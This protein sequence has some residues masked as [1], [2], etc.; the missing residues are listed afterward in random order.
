[1]RSTE[2]V[3]ARLGR[4]RPRGVLFPWPARDS[5]RRGTGASLPRSTC[6]TAFPAVEHEEILW[7]HPTPLP[8]GQLFDASGFDPLKELHGEALD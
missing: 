1:M 3:A 8:P 5:W 6:A 7:L 4:C 2:P